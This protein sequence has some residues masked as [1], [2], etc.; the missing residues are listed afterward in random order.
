MRG[1]ARWN[2]RQVIPNG[3][4]GDGC[5]GRGGTSGKI[6]L[7]VGR[8][9]EPRG[10]NAIDQQ[11][12][13]GLGICGLI[14]MSASASGHRVEHGGHDLW[15]RRIVVGTREE[16]REQMPEF[17]DVCAE[18]QRLFVDDRVC[19]PNRKILKHDEVGP[20]VV[21]SQDHI[22]EHHAAERATSRVQ[23]NDRHQDLGE[24]RH[25]VAH[26]KRPTLSNTR[27]EALPRDPFVDRI[28]EW[29]EH[30]PNER[31][32]D[33]GMMKRRCLVGAQS[34]AGEGA[35]GGGHESQQRAPACAEI[36]DAEAVAQQVSTEVALQPKATRE[37]S[38]VSE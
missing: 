18:G 20:T 32:G 12:H 35:V 16:I 11:F 30:T 38:V 36:Q 5:Q 37:G 19:G 33:F 8:K 14:G 23:G 13:H 3:V 1:G 31:F 29:L 27:F 10:W 15:L 25:E 4:D 21:A 17:F 26:G 28:E 2:G 6:M 9:P 7:F 34:I 22:A 24:D